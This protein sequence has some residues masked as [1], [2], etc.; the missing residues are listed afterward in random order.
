MARLIDI[1]LVM[2]HDQDYC[3]SEEEIRDFMSNNF[4]VLMKNQYR[5]DHTEF[6][7]DSFIKESAFDW[8][9]INT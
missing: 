7:K 9:T 4:L 3:K 2:C 5:F 6:G 8:I 1:Q